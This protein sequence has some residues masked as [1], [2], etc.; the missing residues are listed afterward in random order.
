MV[1]DFDFEEAITVIQSLDSPV[2]T[3]AP[4][5]DEDAVSV[6]SPDARRQREM[7]IADQIAA[8]NDFL[9]SVKSLQTVPGVLEEM[10]T[11]LEASKLV[12]ESNPVDRGRILML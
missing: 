10:A 6:T 8:L 4:L 11:A 1:E 5:S 3:S 12:L 9:N 7:D 2:E